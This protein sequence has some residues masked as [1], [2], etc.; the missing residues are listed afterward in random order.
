MKQDKRPM[1]ALPVRRA[2]ADAGGAADTS[3]EGG[4][5]VVK[6]SD[7]RAQD[8]KAAKAPAGNEA[9]QDYA[10]QNYASRN[11]APRGI[12]ALLAPVTRPVMRKHAPGAAALAEDWEGIAGPDLAAHSLPVKLTGGTLTIGT[13]GPEALAL[14]HRAPQLIARIN[15]ALGRDRVVRLR[16]VQRHLAA[17]KAETN[18]AE[19]TLADT[20]GEAADLPDNLPDGPVGD[21]LA[22]LYQAL[23]RTRRSTQ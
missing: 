19:K 11:Y 14:Q 10:S 5:P 3:R 15:L 18:L 9:T 13:S 1:V 17:P 6:H 2:K 21:A 23:R 22:G 12:A 20:P 16:F 8:G 4:E 7:Q